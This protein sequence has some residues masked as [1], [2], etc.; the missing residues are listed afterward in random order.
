VRLGVL[1]S[2]SR[3]NAFVVEHCGVTVFID[4]GLSGSRH[5]DRLVRSG[6]TDIRP[7]A[8]LISHEHSDHVKGAGIIAR[9]WCIPVCGTTGT[10]RACR[11]YLGRIPGAEILENGSVMDFGDFSISSFSLA[12]DAADPSGFI[13]EWDSGRLGIAT[14]LGRS[15]PLV[16]E[17]LSG[18]TAIVLEFNH[19]EDMLW[20]GSYPWHL[21]QRI[22]SN[23][24][25]LSN[26]TASELLAA[27]WHRD[28]KTCVLAHLSQ[29][30]NLP[31]L[32]EKASREV[33][34]GHVNILTGMQ[35]DPLPALE[36]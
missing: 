2:G 18:C 34:G 31:H 23:T 35:D 14:D 5:H 10:L 12:H 25:H 32:A 30:N 21:K 8:L 29:E 17:S 16:E 1:A 15:S 27:V 19:D 36:L 22:A 20:G 13:I 7:Q 4:A 26:Q 28:M 9:R 24:G 3:G 6:F 11:S 33:A